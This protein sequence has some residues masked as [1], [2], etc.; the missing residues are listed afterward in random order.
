M[1][2]M[3][4]VVAVLVIFLALPPCAAWGH[5][6]HRDTTARALD[7]L[8]D[9]ERDFYFTYA[10]EIISYST[11]PD[12]WRA[13]GDPRGD[14]LFHLSYPTGY[15]MGPQAAAQ[16][17]E[18]L[19]DDL[20]SGNYEEW[21][22]DAGV[23]SHYVGDALCALHTDAYVPEHP[24]I[25]QY[26]NGHVARFAYSPETGQNYADVETA[27]RE[28]S[29]AAHTYYAPMVQAC[30]NDEWGDVESYAI[31]QLDSYASTYATLLCMAY[32]EAFPPEAVIVEPE[33]EESG[34]T[35]AVC[36]ILVV[37]F[38]AAVLAFTRR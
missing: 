30:R 37:A 32:R 2:K 7:A 22:L 16:W 38:V 10:D 8:P 23:L 35:V 11:I 21:A 14:I 24:V 17:Y 12:I 29:R 28:A 6:T 15:G 4:I 3:A 20:S 19:V 31:V 33:N 13:Q 9:E 5:E 27:V 25:E 26:V 18:K 36:M 34:H 1:R